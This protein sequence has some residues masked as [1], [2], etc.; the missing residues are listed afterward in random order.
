MVNLKD[1]KNQIIKMAEF[2][3]QL[4]NEVDSPSDKYYADLGKESSENIIKLLEKYGDTLKKQYFS[5]LIS[6]FATLSIGVEQFENQEVQAKHK[7][8]GELRYEIGQL[9]DDKS[10]NN[11]K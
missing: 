9:K 7:T 10:K 8:F 11:Y 1:Y 5:R 2:Y 3:I 4:P 6:M